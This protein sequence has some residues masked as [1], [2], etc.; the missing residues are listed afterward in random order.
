[1]AEE[2]SVRDQI[3][4]KAQELFLVGGFAKVTTDEVAT[5]LGISKKTIYQHFESKEEL[6]RAA[7]KQMRE[8]V[9]AGIELIVTDGTL[10]FIEKIRQVMAHIGARA[11]N[12]RRPFMED[13]QKRFPDVWEEFQEFRRG[14]ILDTIARLFEEGRREGMIRT[15]IDPD[16]FSLMHLTLI[17]NMIT[18]QFFS[19]VPFTTHQVFEGIRKIMMEGILTDEARTKYNKDVE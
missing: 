17:Q 15:D 16:L 3:V 19:Q 8:E 13:M 14:R 1:M 10:D 4:R 18:P 6:F 9:G 2:Q 7:A 11:S 5:A 12:M